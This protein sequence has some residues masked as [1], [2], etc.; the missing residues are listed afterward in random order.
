[1]AEFYLYR[2]P[3]YVLDYIY[4]QREKNVIVQFTDDSVSSYAVPGVLTQATVSQWPKTPKSIIINDISD[5]DGTTSIDTR[6][7]KDQHWLSSIVIASSVSSI[8]EE[9]FINCESL[10]RVAFTPSSRI[11]KI[12]DGTFCR[13]TALTSFSVPSSVSSIGEDAFSGCSNLKSSFVLPN[14]VKFIGE[15]AF[16]D[17]ISI[18]SDFHIPDSLSAIEQDTFSGCTSLTSTISLPA[19]V[20]CLK[21][22]SFSDCTGIKS[23][24]VPSTVDII[25]VGA[26][27]GCSGVAYVELPFIGLERGNSGVSASMFASIFGF[28]PDPSASTPEWHHVKQHYSY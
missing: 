11:T 1:M 21:T 14:S 25:E 10:S 27:S 24:E 16:K 2:P 13:C 7:F 26:F 20:K 28:D 8:G 15:R 3:P 6:A 12:E 22:G 23:I 5:D 18:Q 17:C 4:G 19:T 9:A